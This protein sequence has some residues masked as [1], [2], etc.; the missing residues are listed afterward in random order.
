[1]C[2][3]GEVRYALDEMNGGGRGIRGL[4]VTRG[5]LGPPGPPGPPGSK[6]DQ[7]N[8]SSIFMMFSYFRSKSFI[9]RQ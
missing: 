4:D 1:M 5:P 3:E 7:V 6:G 2:F 8:T 9:I